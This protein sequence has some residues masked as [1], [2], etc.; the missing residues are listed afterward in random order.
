MFSSDLVVIGK[1]ECKGYWVLYYTNNTGTVLKLLSNNELD[2]VIKNK[3]GVSVI[4]KN[5]QVIVSKSEIPSVICNLKEIKGKVTKIPIDC[6]NINKETVDIVFELKYTTVS[7]ESNLVICSITNKNLYGREPSIEWSSIEE[8]KNNMKVHEDDTFVRDYENLNNFIKEFNL[9]E[10]GRYSRVVPIM[11]I[12]RD[13]N[14]CERR[15]FPYNGSEFYETYGYTENRVFEYPLLDHEILFKSKNGTVYLVSC[16]YLTDGEVTQ[17][18][19]CLAD[20][21]RGTYLDL[22]YKVMGKH[23]SIYVRDNSNMIVMWSE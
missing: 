15:D 22:Q 14:T 9:V 20:N 6:I 5:K 12:L 21:K 1:A 23:S 4:I 19:D 18:M 11:A 2:E 16:P 7:N 3:S 17:Y 13:C 10:Y 8:L